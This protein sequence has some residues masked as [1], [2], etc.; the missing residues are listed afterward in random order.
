[1]KWVLDTNVIS[2]LLRGD[3]TVRAAFESARNMRG[4]FVL[5]P[6]VDY[7][8]RRYLLLKGATR[9]LAQYESLA[10]DWAATPLGLDD[11]R[12]AAS[13]WADRHRLGNPI[14]D[15]DLL[16][17]VTAITQDAVL[18]THNTRHFEGLGARLADWSQP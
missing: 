8:I 7:E 16:I 6:V 10:A 2:Y 4:V 1:V 14:D 5:S 15:A 12:L 13:L 18:V 3:A 17:A 11:W 9:N